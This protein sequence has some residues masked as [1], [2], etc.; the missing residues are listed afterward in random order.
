MGMPQM[1]EKEFLARFHAIN[2][3]HNTIIFL[4]PFLGVTKKITCQCT[5]CG[6]IWEVR[7]IKLYTPTKSDRPPRGCPI[8]DRRVRS[9]LTHAE[10]INNVNTKNK[11][12]KYIQILS[13]YQGD[14]K[15][16]DYRCIL[17]GTQYSVS[18]GNLQNHNAWCEKCRIVHSSFMERFLLHA[19]NHQLPGVS[20]L[21]R[22]KV[23]IGEELDIYI[24]DKNFAI[25]IGS[26]TWHEQKLEKDYN[27]Y[28]K[29]KEANIE[30]LTIYDSCTITDLQFPNCMLYS[31]DL[32]SET[33]YTTLKSCVND[34]L[35]MLSVD[36]IT[37][38]TVWDTITQETLLAYKTDPLEEATK[39]LQNSN[40]PDKDYLRVVKF[41]KVTEPST[42][43]C[44][45]CNKEFT[46]KSRHIA[47]PSS[48]KKNGPCYYKRCSCRKTSY[49][50]IVT[51]WFES[52]PDATLTD[53]IAEFGNSIPKRSIYQ[54]NK[55]FK[56]YSVSGGP[57][58]KKEIVRDYRK[59]NPSKSR[60]EAIKDL[61][62]TLAPNTIRRHWD[63][64]DPNKQDS[65]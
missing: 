37:D 41:T 35:S 50:S 19:L 17:C 54:V 57:R 53:C 23:A 4:S 31:I 42:Y 1:T 52:H 27:K 24:P 28:L 26:M 58:S 9:T 25:E 45:H 16:I 14:S 61:A 5:L 34:V 47:Y 33:G 59:K 6:H 22:D 56:R 40:H 3:S 10:F 63:A 55:I 18:A 65:V 32:G 43:L 8:C 64:T 7:A 11:H 12:A 36:V 13:Q 29:C 46:I 49:N 2:P 51:K 21:H 39:T 44:L 38:H 60:L 30:L 48:K 15:L 20:I 62:K